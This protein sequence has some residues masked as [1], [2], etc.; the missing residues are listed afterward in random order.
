MASEDVLKQISLPIG[1]DKVWASQSKPIGN[2]W[3]SLN[4]YKHI[5]KVTI[6]QCE[7]ALHIVTRF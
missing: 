1:F 2:G 5:C 4:P 7:T 3:R 6:L